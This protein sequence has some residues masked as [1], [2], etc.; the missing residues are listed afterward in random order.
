MR[1]SGGKLVFASIL[2]GGPAED[3]GVAPGDVAVALDGVALTVGNNRR[4]LKSYH[5]GDVLDLVV[6]RGDE[7]ITT[8]IRL[9]TAPEDTCYLSIDDDADISVM[10]RRSDWL[11]ST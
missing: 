11:Q 8:R 9:A 5:H 2:N 6:F 3:A 4:R 1:E 7:L 10:S